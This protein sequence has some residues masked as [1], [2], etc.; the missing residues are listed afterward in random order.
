[1]QYSFSLLVHMQIASKNVH[2]QIWLSI[3]HKIYFLTCQIRCAPARR[4]AAV[5]Q[6]RQR[7]GGVKAAQAA[8][9]AEEYGQK[10]DA[11]MAQFRAL[12]DRGPIAIPKR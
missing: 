10:E 6:R 11:A 3:M 4:Q 9:R 2:C 8:Q 7:F 5:G 1:M 12:L